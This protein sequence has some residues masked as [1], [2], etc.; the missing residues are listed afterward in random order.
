LLLVVLFS[1]RGPSS[2]TTITNT[3]TGRTVTTETDEA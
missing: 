3:D 1:G 2:R